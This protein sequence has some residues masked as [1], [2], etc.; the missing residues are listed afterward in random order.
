LKRKEVEIIDKIT[1]DKHKKYQL[2]HG[3]ALDVLP[4]FEPNVFD[5]VITDPPYASGSTTMKGRMKSTAQ[6]YTDNKI[7]SILPN[8]E[9]DQQDQLSWILWSAVWMGMCKDALKQGG[10]FAFFIDWR[11]VP[12]MSI[13]I[14]M[15]GLT[16]RGTVVWDKRN[17][18]PQKGRFKQQCE[19]IMWGSKGKLDTN[20][21]V[22][23]LPGIYSYSNVQGKKRLHQTQKPIS[24]MSDISK[25]CVPSGLIID[26]FA[27]S[28]STL[29]ACVKDGYRAI[30]IEKTKP[31]YDLA[32]LRLE[33]HIP[34]IYLH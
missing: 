19:F 20:R 25:I 28:G 7:N 5:A 4:K 12:A 29:E 23:I 14:Q 21:P 10:V 11:Q 18:R 27:G 6:K 3:D 9:G 2:I 22:S 16:H 32:K 8:F 34:D 33:E 26:P 1:I 30:G 15:A 17:S 31:Y 24:L 13:A